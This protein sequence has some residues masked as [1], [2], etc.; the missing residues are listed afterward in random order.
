MAAR[1]TI[2]T[3]VDRW[4]DATGQ[5]LVEQITAVGDYLIALETHKAAVK[6][7]PKDKIMLRNR[8]RVLERR[9]L[10]RL[11]RS[12]RR[13]S[14]ALATALAAPVRPRKG[15]QDTQSRA[16]VVLDD[17]STLPQRD[18]CTRP[19]LA[20]CMVGRQGHG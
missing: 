4:D 3:T 20:G 13:S 15:K 8:A 5:N 6:R 16:P 10:A 9:L 17:V 14:P 19:A 11:R 12:L 7:W 2:P 1:P 18:C